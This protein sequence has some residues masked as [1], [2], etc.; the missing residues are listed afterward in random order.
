M[1]YPQRVDALSDVDVGG[2]SS[3]CQWSSLLLGQSRLVQ[4]TFRKIRDAQT[5]LDLETLTVSIFFNFFC[6]T[7]VGSFISWLLRCGP[8]DLNSGK[9]REDEEQTS[10]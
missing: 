1:V 4:T 2:D 8:E 5:R 7:F 6:P 3:D 10:S 9:R